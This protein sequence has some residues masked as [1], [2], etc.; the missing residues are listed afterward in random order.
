ME[1]QELIIQPT[2]FSHIQGSATLTNFFFSG[3][4]AGLEEEVRAQSARP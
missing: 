2:L 4:L 3:G 1:L